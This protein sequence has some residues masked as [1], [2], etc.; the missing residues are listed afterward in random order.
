MIGITLNSDQIRLAPADVRQWIEREVIGSLGLQ[1]RLATVDQPQQ[2][3]LAS[4]N[5][6]EVAAILNQIQGLLPVVNV[7]FE[8]GRQGA[9]IPQSSVEAFRLLDIAH[10]TRLQDVGQV[11]ACLDVINEAL[12]HVRQDGNAIFCAFDREGH[13][14]VAVET[15][16]N[17]LKLWQNV[18]SSQQLAPDGQNMPPLSPL[19][20]DVSNALTSDVNQAPAERACGD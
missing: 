18:I 14:F 3:H 13:C 6:D 2:E 4:C 19:P 16:Q 9:V 11:V 5:A 20:N 17:I 15:Q 12:G 10:H 8:F 7:F 1:K